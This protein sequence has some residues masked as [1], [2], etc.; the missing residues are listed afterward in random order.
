[1][2]MFASMQNTAQKLQTRYM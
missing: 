1:M 2:H